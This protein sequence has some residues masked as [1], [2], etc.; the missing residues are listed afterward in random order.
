MIHNKTIAILMISICL[1]AALTGCAGMINKEYQQP[2][3]ALPDQW[4][5]QPETG[6]QVLATQQWW[7]VFEDPQ[8]DRLI[9]LALTTNNDLA[10]ATIKVRK[11]RLS[12][13]LEATNRTP[14]L[15]VSASSGIK[16]DL[17]HGDRTESS[18]TTTSLSWELDLWGKLASSRD[19]AEWEARA[20]AQ[21]RAATALSLVGTTAGLYWQIAYLNQAIDTSKE[22]IAYT[23]RTLDLVK[24]KYDAGE[25][26][27]LDLLQAEQ[28]VESQKADLADLEQQMVE[29]RNALAVLFDQA[30]EHLMADPKR[31]IEMPMPALDAGLPAAVLG[32]RPDLMAAEMRLRSTLA[33]ANSTRASYY[34]NLSL[35]GALGTSSTELFNFLQNPVASLGAGLALP[36]VQWNEAKLN[37]RIAEADY[38]QA[39]VEFRQTLYEAL[40]EVEDALSARKHYR[41]QEDALRR[42]LTL[43]EE[44]ERVSEVRYTS[45]KTGVQ[46]WL[47]QQETRRSADLALAKNR[48]NQ[49]KNMMTLYQALG[50]DGTV[51]E[52]PQQE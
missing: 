23:Q 43:A 38:E 52:E 1:L 40:Q 7:Q 6:E 17:E 34:P 3:V 2:E 22:G 42:S 11:S 35:T 13:D 47:D 51:A 45:G 26:S 32:S 10:A 9:E 8:L 37:T 16:K 48:Y 4:L 36:F 44:A 33:D 27:R 39:V 49:L 46:D 12:A 30:P 41:I 5:I 29:A 50:G 31:L 24:V 21:D 18:G 25:V 15:S 19:A 20:T 14:D 28:N